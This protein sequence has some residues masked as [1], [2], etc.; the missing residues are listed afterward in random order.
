LVLYENPPS[1]IKENS[2]IIKELT[3]K[4]IVLMKHKAAKSCILLILP[5]SNSTL[6]GQGTAGDRSHWSRPF[7]AAAGI[8]L[9]C[10]LNKRWL[11]CY[12]LLRATR[13]YN[14]SSFK[15]L[16]ENFIASK[17]LVRS[18]LRQKQETLTLSIRRIVK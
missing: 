2:F 15:Y 17:L 14:N 6:N 5:I 18:D 13:N 16:M 11:P 8:Q 4:L 9:P 3:E 1:K 12:A 10:F 7:R